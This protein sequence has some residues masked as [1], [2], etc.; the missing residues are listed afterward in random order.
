VAL[1][2]NGTDEVS[3][4]TAVR[5]FMV[6]FII[7]WVSSS[8]TRSLRVTMEAARKRNSRPSDREMWKLLMTEVD[9]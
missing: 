7:I 9:A 6:T 3:S 1:I 8:V 5:V 2:V 4:L